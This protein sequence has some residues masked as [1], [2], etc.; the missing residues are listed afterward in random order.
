M[1]KANITNEDLVE[2][3]NRMQ[4]TVDG[5]NKQIN[6]SNE[7]LG[8]DIKNCK[9]EL[10]DEIK[11]I[12]KKFE[13]Q[14]EEVKND[15]R[16]AKDDIKT[17]MMN[18]EG[19]LERIEMEKSELRKP[20]QEK[21]PLEKKDDDERQASAENCEVLMDKGE[22][23]KNKYSDK[24][25]GK[26]V[27]V[28]KQRST[29]AR[30][31]SQISLEEQLKIATEA[32]QKLEEGGEGGETEFWRGE[33]RMKSE[34]RMKLGDSAELHD[35]QDWAWNGSSNDW[36]GTIDREGKNRAKKEK[37]EEKRRRKREKAVLVGKSTIGI[38]PI[39]ER[40]INYFF[41]I[42]AD[43]SEAK[44]MAATEFLTEYLRFDN[45][46][47]CD[48]DITDTKMSGKNDEIMYVVCSSPT[49]VRDIRRRIADCRNDN[50]KTREY[51]PPM[52]FERYSALGRYAASLRADDERLK[53][54]IRFVEND[55][56][57]FTKEKGT[58]EPFEPVD[59]EELRKKINLPD[60]DYSVVWR[61]REERQ[62]WRRVSPDRRRVCLKSLGSCEEENGPALGR[63]REKSTRK[64][65]GNSEQPK[66]KKSK[67]N[68]MESSSSG[69]G[70]S[71]SDDEE[72]ATQSKK[73]KT[74]KNTVDSAMDTS[75]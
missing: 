29:W 30:K 47:M 61:K 72:D 46:D 66:L 26:E 22:P 49:K 70:S 54:Q 5:I 73:K 23:S 24:V 31:M 4:M 41:N 6:Y 15:T 16:R 9:D 7:A 68:A 13:K 36:D 35:M 3:M 52:F 45:R 64:T 28:P 27:K 57:L 62:P 21:E 14:L 75:K 37:E 67:P 40:S 20:T 2:F 32:A 10:K 51:I 25:K 74:P 55:I 19:R 50:I 12:N 43:Y 69:S 63:T 33:R 42:T 18:M 53:T 56:T 44:K 11:G 1:T 38:G 39:K 71:S 65:S 59:M 48:T 34:Y 58:D 8:R 17:R 60:V